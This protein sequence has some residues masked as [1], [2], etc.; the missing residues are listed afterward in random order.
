[1]TGSQCMKCRRKTPNA[2]AHFEA[3]SVKGHARK[4][5]KSQCAVCGTK[6]S[7]FVSTGRS[8]KTGNGFI[9]KTV[10]GLLG[11][12]AGGLLPF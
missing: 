7:E 12:L 2:N 9:G 6:K 4:M 3:I 10:G 8:S 1:M 5:L 11:G